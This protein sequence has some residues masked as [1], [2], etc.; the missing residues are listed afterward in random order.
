MYNLH[1]CKYIGIYVYIYVH[2]NVCISI[3]YLCIVFFLFMYLFAIYIYYEYIYI[4]TFIIT[5]IMYIIEKQRGKKYFWVSTFL[6]LD[7]H[8]L[9]VGTKRWKSLGEKDYL[10]VSYFQIYK[11]DVPSCVSRYARIEYAKLF[12]LVSHRVYFAKAESADRES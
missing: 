10:S 9:I 7:C 11:S 8:L 12:V 5:C 2:I 3:L 1:I 4:I 6:K